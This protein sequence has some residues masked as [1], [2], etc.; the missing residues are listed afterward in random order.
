MNPATDG[1]VQLTERAIEI[2]DAA[3][4]LLEREG[5][6]GLVIRR[7]CDRVGVRAPAIYRRFPDKRAIENAIVSQVLW[8]CGDVGLRAAEGAEDPLAAIASAYRAWA[9]EHP[10][11]YRITFGNP[12]TGGIDPAAERYS[13]TA[14]RDATGGDLDAA[15]AFWAFFHGMV[16]LEL[17]GR[18]PPGS[19]L[20]AIWRFG[21]EGI[22]RQFAR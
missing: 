10:H 18:F 14:L 20:D 5:P 7:L 1:T 11:L 15:R 22:R 4:E 17:D 6:D 8:E 21:L 9:L 2:R 12:L 16:S 3:R 13:G 19:D